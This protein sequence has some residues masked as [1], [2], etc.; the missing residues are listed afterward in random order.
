M[1]KKRKPANINIHRLTATDSS[2]N[3]YLLISQNRAA[4]IDVIHPEPDAV[5]L[6]TQSGAKLQYIFVTHAHPSRLAGALQMQKQFGARLCLHEFEEELLNRHYPEARPDRL[7]QDNE[8]FALGDV[9][10]RALLTPGHTKG[11]V[12]FWIK[13]ADAL[14]SGSTLLKGK[15]GRIWGPKSMSLMLFSLKRI[16]YTVPAETIVYPGRGEQ[17]ILKK[18]GWMNCLRSA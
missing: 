2:Q 7:I 6:L 12:C 15:F 9:T 10:I 13:A 18:E 17:T 16:N 1:W 11:S 5:S 4:A 8:T 3:G 14:F